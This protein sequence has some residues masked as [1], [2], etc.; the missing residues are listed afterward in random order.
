MPSHSHSHSKER[1][2]NLTRKFSPPFCRYVKTKKVERKL[3]KKKKT[4]RK[5]Y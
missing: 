1:K 4:E 2:K 3:K 5:E